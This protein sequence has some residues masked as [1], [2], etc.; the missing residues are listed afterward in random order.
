[1]ERQATVKV[2]KA[3]TNGD[4]L[5]EKLAPLVALRQLD[6]ADATFDA[7][8]QK[9][10]EKTVE[11]KGT[12]TLQISG[13]DRELGIWCQAYGTRDWYVQKVDGGDV[14]LV[15]DELLRTL[16][17]ARSRLPDRRLSSLDTTEI[18][19]AN[20]LLSD[21][22][23]TLAAA[24]LDSD[25]PEKATWKA[26]SLGNSKEMRTQLNSWMA[27][28]LKL[29]GSSYLGPDE[30]LEAPVEHFR[31]TWITEDGRNQTVVIIKDG[32]NWWAT[33]EHTR[34]H[35]KLVGAKVQTL[36]EGIDLLVNGAEVQ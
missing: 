19:G 4:T 27:S 30:E 9:D 10:K 8:C 18:V 36:V 23:S 29:N 22:G 24:Q 6:S 13:T 17:Q 20:L 12:M 34:G 28:M 2:Y 5:V 26:E 25:L 1:M 31:V 33:S 16:N 32:D 35:L 15:D 3:G 7:L 14:Y 21:S 11:A